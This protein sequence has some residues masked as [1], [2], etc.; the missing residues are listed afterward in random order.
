MDTIVANVCV[1][2]PSLKASQGWSARSQTSDFS[3]HSPKHAISIRY[4][5]QALWKVQYPN[6]STLTHHHWTCSWT[7][8]Q[9][10]KKEMLTGI[11]LRHHLWP[12]APEEVDALYYHQPGTSASQL[13]LWQEVR[14]MELPTRAQVFQTGRATAEHEHI[15]SK[16]FSLTN[17]AQQLWHLYTKIQTITKVD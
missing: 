8:K 4:N 5:K 11:S 16:C 12:Y 17:L 10:K 6:I 15:L 3:W 14:W 13:V 2:Y 7:R 9:S 1:R